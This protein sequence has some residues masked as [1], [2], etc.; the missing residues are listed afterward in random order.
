MIVWFIVILLA[1]VCILFTKDDPILTEVKRRYA[2]LRKNLPEDMEELRNKTVITGFREKYG[3][4][5]YNVNKGQEIGLCIDGEPNEV[6]HVLIHELAH[7]VTRSWAHNE[8]FWHNYHTLRD[9]C[10]KLGIYKKLDK[11]TDF[12]GKYI[13]D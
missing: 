2:I 8:K 7:T 6:F 10:V 3:E 13:R 9:Q 1:V 5:G 4:L 12:C 11:N